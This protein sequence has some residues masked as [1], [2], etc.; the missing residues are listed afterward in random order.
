MNS[1]YDKR[2]KESK[3]IKYMFGKKKEKQL[4]EQLDKVKAFI[5]EKYKALSTEFLKMTSL[6]GDAKT[7]FNTFN[8]KYDENKR[9][10][11]YINIIS[12]ELKNKVCEETRRLVDAENGINEIHK[13][14]QIQSLSADE[15]NAA[16]KDMGLRIDKASDDG[17]HILTNINEIEKISDTIKE[18]SSKINVLSLNTAILGAKYDN[19]KDGFVQTAT[20]IKNL[21][22]ECS[23]VINGMNTN[24]STIQKCVKDSES[25]LKD[26]KLIIKE[27]VESSNKNFLMFENLKR[28]SM[29]ERDNIMSF[30][31]E[32]RKII[33]SISE[34]R[35]MAN[36]L[37][38]KQDDIFLM[39][40]HFGENI[41]DTEPI[42]SETQRQINELGRTN[43]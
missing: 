27:I 23:N 18:I 39:I 3:G 1:Y 37:N 11:S 43:D 35:D 34:F 19:E 22:T 32:Y 20:D 25:E 40:K 17:K 38:S 30:G 9:D 42:L 31:V 8:Q 28:E 14:A 16:S 12:E 6:M 13:K 41:K 2:V 21:S 33:D 5:D 24:I 4:I 29:H 26:T 36:E 15:L 10:I 7:T